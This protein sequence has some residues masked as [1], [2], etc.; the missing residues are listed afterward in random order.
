M[1]V[2]GAEL[3]PLAV[4]AQEGNTKASSNDASNED[5]PK[6]SIFIGLGGKSSGTK[7]FKT[8]LH[9]RALIHLYVLNTMVE[10]KPYI[11]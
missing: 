7:P 10:V 11:K 1:D 6:L 2:S 5:V 4:S 3:G 9:E 8:N